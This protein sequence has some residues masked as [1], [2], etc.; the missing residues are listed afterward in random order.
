MTKTISNELNHSCTFCGFKYNKPVPKMVEKGQEF[1]VIYCGKCH[2]ME[3]LRV[4]PEW[5]VVYQHKM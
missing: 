5:S 3:T 2:N 1:N 4:G